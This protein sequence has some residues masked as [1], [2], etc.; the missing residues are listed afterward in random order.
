MIDIYWARQLKKLV[1]ITTPI[2]M[3]LINPYPPQGQHFQD[4][5]MWGLSMLLIVSYITIY[6]GSTPF[7]AAGAD[8]ATVAVSSFVL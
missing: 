1:H 3:L 7:V 4:P 2:A 6:V 8:A 5:I